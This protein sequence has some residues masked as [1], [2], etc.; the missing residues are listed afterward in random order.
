MYSGKRRT[1]VKKQTVMLQELNNVLATSATGSI[2]EEDS[3]SQDD[4][5]NIEDGYS[6]RG[7]VNSSPENGSSASKGRKLSVEYLEND[8]DIFQSVNDWDGMKIWTF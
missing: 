1:G 8:V 2:S 5:E 7:E 6:D 3:I 4:L